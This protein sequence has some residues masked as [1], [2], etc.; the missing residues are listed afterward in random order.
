MSARYSN[1]SSRGLAIVVE[2]VIGST[3]WI[4]FSGWPHAATRRAVHA[5]PGLAAHAR[6]GTR[7]HAP[8]STTSSS[9]ALICDPH[10]VAE[11]RPVHE[12]RIDRLLAVQRAAQL[13]ERLTRA[14]RVH[15]LA[16]E[17]RALAARAALAFGREI[18]HAAAQQRQ[19]EVLHLSPRGVHGTWFRRLGD[20]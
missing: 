10:R 4:L 1:T 16:H 18:V 17:R 11:L 20:R 2:T 14:V 8:G 9:C 7:A 12:L 3:A 19:L 15:T 6:P 5:P 13:A